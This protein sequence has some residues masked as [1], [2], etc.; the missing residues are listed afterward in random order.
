[1]QEFD[2]KKWLYVY[3]VVS[4][5]AQPTTELQY[6]LFFELFV[7]HFEDRSEDARKQY[8]EEFDEGLQQSIV[9]FQNAL[10]KYI[11]EN[12]EDWTGFAVGRIDKETWEKIKDF[13]EDTYNEKFEIK[14][15]G[16]H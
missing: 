6:K 7:L 15:A 5:Y 10:P 12:I 8:K 3:L 16:T 13:Y 14:R 1:M 11:T 2:L 9:A 4:R